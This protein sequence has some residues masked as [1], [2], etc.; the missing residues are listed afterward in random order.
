MNMRYRRLGHAGLQVS[1]LSLGSW[2]TFG[3]QITDDTA[4]AL[5]KLAYDNGV[6]FFDNAE[7]YARGESE[8]VMGRIL[9]RMEWPRDT[10]TVSSKVFFGAGGKLP[11]QIG[12]HRKHVVEACHAALQRLQVEHLDLF[13]CHR[14][15]PNTPIGETVWTMHQLIMQGKVMYWGTSEWSADQI[16]EAHAFAQAHHLIGPTME[17]PQYNLFHREKVER[18]FAS[19][20]D[21]V[22]LG[23]TI[24][25]PLASGI[26]S[27]K[28]TPEGDA[29]SRLRMEGLDW[30][31]ERELTEAR[32]RKVEEL[33][34]MA[35]ELGLSLP[36]FAIAWCL[37]NPRVST[38]MLG[39]SKVPQLEENLKA[40][41]AQDKLTPEVMARVE[42]ALAGE[43][44]ST[45]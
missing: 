41:E 15:D 43:K 38:V 25:S 19:L 3:K 22:G 21:T 34:A 39:A 26:L 33:K 35:K 11:T 28:H 9:R 40:V 32:L 10:W 24:W 4:E 2:L 42:N 30:L 27:G 5:M 45:W 23:T 29:S 37:K 31:R 6:N 17:Q 44:L 7:I 36:V 8:R 14:P 13:F 1:E 18:E 12:L 16:K 20:Y